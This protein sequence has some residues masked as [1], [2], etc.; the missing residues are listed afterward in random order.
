MILHSNLVVLY[1]ITLD[2]CRTVD[3]WVVDYI[4]KCVGFSRTSFSLSTLFVI[5]VSLD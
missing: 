3:Y 1:D 2:F 4:N 5:L